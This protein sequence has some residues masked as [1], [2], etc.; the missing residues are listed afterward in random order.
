MKLV[1]TSIV[2]L[3]ATVAFANTTAPTAA[4]T[5]APAATAEKTTEKT[6]TT[7]KTETKTA[8]TAAPGKVEAKAATADCAKLTGEA[9]TKCETAAKTH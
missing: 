6:T 9:K 2:A 7:T 4:A 1:A 8:K 5:T 3:F